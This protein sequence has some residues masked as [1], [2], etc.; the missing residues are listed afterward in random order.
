MHWLYD[1]CAQCVFRA[2]VSR[3][4]NSSGL[5]HAAARFLW[6]RLRQERGSSKGEEREREAERSF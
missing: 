4:S 3:V 5:S 2:S 1:S 6:R